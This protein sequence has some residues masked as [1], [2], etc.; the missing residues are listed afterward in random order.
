MRKMSRAVEVVD[1]VVDVVD[2]KTRCL[3]P[4]H[5]AGVAE[6][7]LHCAYRR[8]H[9]HRLVVVVDMAMHT[10]AQSEMAKDEHRLRRDYR[11]EDEIQH[12]KTVVVA[13]NDN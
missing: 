13:K 10:D 8:M 6:T 9:Q 4:L 1:F 12:Q 7:T 2:C 5:V 3:P 11:S